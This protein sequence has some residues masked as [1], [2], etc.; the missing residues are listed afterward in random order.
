MKKTHEYRRQKL[1][2]S[3]E[4]LSTLHALELDQIRGGYCTSVSVMSTIACLVC[5]SGAIG[6]GQ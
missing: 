3:R 4:T 6:T 2:L 1:R 5:I